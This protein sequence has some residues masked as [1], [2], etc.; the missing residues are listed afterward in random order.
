M[1]YLACAKQQCIKKYTGIVI[2]ETGLSLVALFVFLVLEPFCLRLKASKSI[3]G[4][5]L[6]MV[7]IKVLAYAD[8]VAVCCTD[9]KSVTQMIEGT[10]EYCEAT[11]AVVDWQKCCGFWHRDWTSKPPICRNKLE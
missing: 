4:Y 7:E 11:G 1:Y 2:S 5:T 10:K 3:R 6:N 8:D 9:K